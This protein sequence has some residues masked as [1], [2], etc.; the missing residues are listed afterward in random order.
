M[1]E[2]LFLPHI[3]GKPYCQE[4]RRED[5]YLVYEYAQGGTMADAL[6]DESRW[7]RFSVSA[8]RRRLG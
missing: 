1:A 3:Y 6:K 2:C 4:N 7:D 5:S 8:L